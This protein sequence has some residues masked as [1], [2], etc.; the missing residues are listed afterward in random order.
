MLAGFS[1]KPGAPS[2]ANHRVGESRRSEAST[3]HVR[4]PDRTVTRSVARK[5]EGSAVERN[6]SPPGTGAQKSHGF[7]TEDDMSLKC[8]TFLVAS[9][10]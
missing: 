5:V 3:V 2:Y 10:A 6:T 8:V 4:H 9:T 7:T 1:H